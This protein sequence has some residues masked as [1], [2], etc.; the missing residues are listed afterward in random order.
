LP[1]TAGRHSTATA[2]PALPRY[3]YPHLVTGSLYGGSRARASR[4]V[5]IRR[6]KHGATETWLA[7]LYGVATPGETKRAEATWRDAASRNGSTRAAA[8]YGCYGVR[9][10]REGRVGRVK[11]GTHYC[12]LVQRVPPLLT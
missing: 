4:V 5:Y 7:R 8:F 3:H 11:H 6:K 2:T 10:Q 12:R 9:A 1:A